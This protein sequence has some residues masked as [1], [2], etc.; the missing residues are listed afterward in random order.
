MAYTAIDDPEAYFQV[1]LYTG[2]GS[3]NALTF[4][5]DTDMQ[6]DI[7]WIKQRSS[8]EQH[9]VFDSVRGVQKYVTPN[10]TAAEGD[11]A[12]TLTAFGSDGFTEGGH[13]ITGQSS[14]TYVAWAWKTQGGAGSSNEDGGIN[15]TSTSVNQT[16][17]VSISTWTGTGSTATVGHGLGAVPR[18]I[19]T[20]AR[21]DAYDWYTYHA[22]LGNT[23]NVYI[24]LNNA[25]SSAS[26]NFHNNTDPTSSVWTS[27]GNIYNVDY[28]F[29]TYAFAEKQGFSKFGHY[30]G[31][32]N[33]DGTFVYT[34][35]R[36]AL[37]ITKS[38]DSTSAW[39]I[40]DNKREGYNHDNDP[41][42]AEATTAEATTD[43]IDLL[44]NGFKFKIATDP[45]V[46]ET[47]IYVAFAEAPFVNSNGV[48]CNAR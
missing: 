19:T 38:L 27:G 35:F 2:T 40:F 46:A 17:G 13:G 34:G 39:H 15:T 30:E 4:D 9:V 47:Y 23:K 5:G 26:A 37:V 11:T 44:S 22:S 10:T 6:P 33:A 31:N 20:K 16:S 28:T 24:N 14:A 8:T 7:V 42:V 18:F 21:S 3:S 45:N 43:M 25:A 32:G 41:L 29:V 1:K 12:T 36:P 48:P